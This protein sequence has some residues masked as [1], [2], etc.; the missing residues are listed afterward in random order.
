M[1]L[2]SAY[3]DSINNSANCWLWKP[4]Y[5]RIRFQNQHYSMV[6]VG[7]PG[8]GKSYLSLHIAEMLYPKFNPLESVVFSAGDFSKIIANQKTI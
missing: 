4:I 1:V 6:I 2:R 5:R 8:S 7:K 3:P